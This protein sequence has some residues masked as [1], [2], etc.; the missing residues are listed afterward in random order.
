MSTPR[1]GVRRS[2]PQR[3][4]PA[5]RPASEAP[6]PPRPQPAAAAA[7]ATPSVAAAPGPQQEALGLG[8]RILEWAGWVVLWISAVGAGYLLGKIDVAKA[9]FVAILLAVTV[10]P[11]LRWGRPGGPRRLP[12]SRRAMLQS[13]LSLLVAF[14]LVLTGTWIWALALVVIELASTTLNVVLHARHPS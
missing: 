11:W 6:R 12:S 5:A 14:C 3:R 4:P 13:G 8:W 2:A 7:A 10:L 9:L 1:R